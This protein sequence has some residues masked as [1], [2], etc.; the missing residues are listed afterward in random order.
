MKKIYILFCSFRR[1]KLE[2]VNKHELLK[3]HRNCVKFVKAWE[4]RCS[5]MLVYLIL[6]LLIS[7]GSN[8][9]KF[10]FFCPFRQHLYIQTELC[11]MRWITIISSFKIIILIDKSII[12]IWLCFSLNQL[13]N[14]LLTSNFCLWTP[15]SVKDLHFH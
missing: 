7:K 14:R 10:N 8:V 12:L 15:S 13:S 5:S 3:N 9:F 2:E 1:Y 11:E 4:E 6:I